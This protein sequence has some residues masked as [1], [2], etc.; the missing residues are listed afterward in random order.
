LNKTKLKSQ[1][2]L[3]AYDTEKDVNKV[4]EIIKLKEWSAIDL[5]V[6]PVFHEQ[7]Q[8]IKDLPEVQNKVIVNP[9]SLSSKYADKRGGY[10]YKTCVEA[11]VSNMVN[12]ATGNFQLR[13]NVAKDPGVIEKKNVVV[14]FGKEPKD[15][16]M[17]YLY[18]DSIISRG[19]NVKLFL[20]V[21]LDYMGKLR[22][23]ASDSVGLINISHFAT[24]SNDA[25]F[26]AN[27][28]SLLEGTLQ[29]IPIYA[30]SDW[31]DNTQLSYVQM[32][33][34]NVHFVYPD[35][36]R[37]N[38]DSYKRFYKAY[39]AK[40]SV[41]PSIYALQGYEMLLVFGKAM[42]EGGTDVSVFLNKQK[43]YSADIL[44]GYD[45]SNANYNKFVPIAVFKDMKLNLVNEP[46]VEDVK[47]K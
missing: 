41:Y 31:L 21:D 30:Y 45:Y 32:E 43:F 17:A 14:L 26:A 13:K 47:S 42:R 39:L 1:F 12:Y 9:F 20:K 37:I 18:R 33:K 44:G 8:Y 19:F 40:Y 5:V 4:A 36:V 25:V 46:K 27:F 29:D 28:I 38:S 15:S 22:K 11:I 3:H 23:I 6:G 35:F 16:V 10:L 34:R 2:E 7:Y 24:F